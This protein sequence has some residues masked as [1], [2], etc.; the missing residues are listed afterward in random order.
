MKGRQMQICFK[1]LNLQI[2]INCNATDNKTRGDHAKD[3]KN[4]L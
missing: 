3:H 1:N 4:G 2:Q